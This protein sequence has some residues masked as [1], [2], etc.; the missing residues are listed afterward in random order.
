MPGAVPAGTAIAWPPTL[1][2][3]RSDPLHASHLRFRKRA[4]APRAL[5]CFV[6]D[7]SASMLSHERLA[8]AK[9][10]IVAYFDQA[11]RERTETALICFGG[12]GAARRFGPAVPRW[13]NARWLEPVDGGGGTPLA[14]GIAAAAQMLARDARRTPAAGKQRWL[15]VL[16]DGR[17]RETPPKPVD[18]DH[19]VFVDF[20]DAAVRVGQGRRLADA[21][22]A[23]WTTA[24]ALC[25]GLAG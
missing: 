3:K 4:G 17:T 9:G 25:A 19:V 24:A 12:D 6:L 18:A 15:W 22:G 21:W 8:L 5:H 13:W 10:L 20:D 23:Q 7:C 16:S 2:A 11:A 1:A 14:D